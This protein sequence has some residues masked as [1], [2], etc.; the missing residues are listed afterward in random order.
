VNENFHL[1]VDVGEGVAE[2]LEKSGAD[3]SSKSKIISDIPNAVLITGSHDELHIPYLLLPVS[4][5]VNLC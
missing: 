2:S 5:Q 3:V 1:L 4:A